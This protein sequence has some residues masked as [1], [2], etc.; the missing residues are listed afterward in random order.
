M[1]VALRRRDLVVWAGA[2][3]ACLVAV[4][5]WPEPDNQHIG[6]IV[7]ADPGPTR[8][9]LQSAPR[10]E[11]DSTWFMAHHDLVETEAPAFTW[12][13]QEKSPLMVSTALRPD[14]FD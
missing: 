8:S 7:I 13:V 12:P 1:R 4:R 14:L 9:T 10:P 2:A 3:A 6:P 5:F 11:S